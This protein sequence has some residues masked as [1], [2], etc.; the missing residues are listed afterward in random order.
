M[1][2]AGSTDVDS[3]SYKAIDTF[4][5]G[6]I[7]MNIDAGEDLH[8]SLQK[9]PSDALMKYASTWWYKH[10]KISEEKHDQH[11]IEL[12]IQI[13]DPTSRIFEHI[14]SRLP[15]QETYF[16]DEVEDALGIASLLGLER[17]VNFLLSKCLRPR[18]QSS[19]DR[20]LEIAVRC[21]HC[22]IA[23]SLLDTGGDPNTQVLS[24]WGWT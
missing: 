20:A 9:L 15:L 16:T 23:K 17:V 6:S 5:N 19:I 2:R 4:E 12:A 14:K 11:G 24:R 8:S 7:S 1:N 21:E 3:D 22:A 18:S 10:F 13:C